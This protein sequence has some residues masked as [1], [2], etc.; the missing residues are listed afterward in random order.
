MIYLSLQDSDEDD[1][2]IDE[3]CDLTKVTIKED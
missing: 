2:H 3:C 1:E